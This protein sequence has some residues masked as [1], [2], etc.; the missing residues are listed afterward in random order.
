MS[1]K[2][3]EF[4]VENHSTKKTKLGAGDGR[5]WECRDITNKK[6]KQGPKVFTG[7]FYQTSKGTT[8]ILQNLFQKTEEGIL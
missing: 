1:I 4:V 8:I 5:K 3:I 7:E 6:R 2:G